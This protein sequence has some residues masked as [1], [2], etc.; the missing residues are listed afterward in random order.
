MSHEPGGLSGAVRGFCCVSPHLCGKQK[1]ARAGRGPDAGYTIGFKETD[2]DQTRTGRGQRR[3]SP[4]AWVLSRCASRDVTTQGRG[5]CYRVDF[6]NTRTSCGERASPAP[7]HPI[8]FSPPPP[9]HYNTASARVAATARR[10][11]PQLTRSRPPR[12]PLQGKKRKRAR[13]GR[14]LAAGR[15]IGFEETD[16]DRA[17]A[18]PLLPG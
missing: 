5:D 12:A 10:A 9:S 17:R 14:R 2:T 18:W 15:T 4:S 8:L 3:S 11:P 13:T 6:A 7:P 1:L 16:A